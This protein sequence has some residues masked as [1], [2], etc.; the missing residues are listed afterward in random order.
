MHSAGMKRARSVEE[1]G[2]VGAPWAGID[3]I[4]RRR[5]RQSGRYRCPT[6]VRPGDCAIEGRSYNRIVGKVILRSERMDG[7]LG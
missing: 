4:D 7:L 6:T 2:A 1:T 5:E 3:R